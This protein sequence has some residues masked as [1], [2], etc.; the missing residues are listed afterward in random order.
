MGC[1]SSH[2]ELHDRL[3]AAEKR[4]RDIPRGKKNEDL[5]SLE[6]IAREIKDIFMQ[7]AQAGAKDRDSMRR[8]EVISDQILDNLVGRISAEELKEGREV[9]KEWLGNIEKVAK[10]LDAVRATKASSAVTEQIESTLKSMS[11]LVEQAAQADLLKIKKGG[12]VLK[13]DPSKLIPVSKEIIEAAKSAN[14]AAPDSKKVTEQLLTVIMQ[15]S[16]VILNQWKLWGTTYK[17]CEEMLKIATE[18]DELATRLVGIVDAT[19]DPPLLPEVKKMQEKCAE[20]ICTKSIQGAEAQLKASNGGAAFQALQQI[21]PW[22]PVLKEKDGSDLQ[23][24]GIFSKIA[25]F[26]SDQYGKALGDEAEKESI[27]GFVTEVENLR[28]KFEGLA[29]PEGESSLGE[30]LSAIEMKGAVEK[31]LGTLATLIPNFG[32]KDKT[33]ISRGLQ[34]LQAVAS[35]WSNVSSDAALTEKLETNCEKIEQWVDAQVLRTQ[36]DKIA[37]F[38]KLATEYDDRRSR[39]TPPEPKQGALLP[40]IKLRAVAGYLKAIEDGLEAAKPAHEK[41]EQ[42]ICDYLKNAADIVPE[43]ETKLRGR[44]A[45]AFKKTDACLTDK[46]KNGLG[47]PDTNEK[48]EVIL[49]NFAK[50]VDEIR[51]GAALMELLFSDEGSSLVKRLEALKTNHMG[52]LVDQVEGKVAAQ[53]FEQLLDSLQNLESVAS[54][55]PLEDALQ[56]RLQATLSSLK[57][58]FVEACSKAAARGDMKTV[59]DFEFQAPRIDETIVSLGFASQGL[60]AGVLDIVAGAHLDAAKRTLIAGDG[61]VIDCAA[62]TTALESLESCCHKE[63]C[64]DEVKSNV[65]KLATPLETALVASIMSETDGANV[66]A[67]VKAA[68]VADQALSATEDGDPLGLISQRV[69]VAKVVG[70]KLA[71]AKKELDKPERSDPRVAVKVLEQLQGDWEPVKDVQAC[72]QKL[73]AVLN[74]LHA[75]LDAACKKALEADGE[76]KEKKLEGLVQLAQQADKAQDSL[77]SLSKGL[78]SKSFAAGISIALANEHLSAIEAELSKTSGMQPPELLK[79]TKGL[80]KIWKDVAEADDINTRWTQTH[81]KIKTRMAE[82]MDDAIKSSAEGKKKALLHFAKEFDS[83]CSDFSDGSLAEELKGK[84]ES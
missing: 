28:A 78:E 15:V 7:L 39:C 43:G 79:H 52:E 21:L 24:A 65:K 58:P 16:G 75:K 51:D 3:D 74:Q 23:I 45:E 2:N 19:W 13:K 14:N 61:G 47:T 42:S 71:E 44:L 77:A 4:M 37:G 27:K 56:S 72:R 9:C 8:V 53:D 54:K 70:E 5:T 11:A 48:K 80:A 49:I 62:L 6:S 50:I 64:S 25:T 32:P 20:E 81:E 17:N 55:T 60:E 35:K 68:A 10:L 38:L 63:G 41:F 34:A 33:A 57:D 83:A 22:W 66:G 67:I 82:S 59:G 30:T 69:K 76:T 26:T 18:V 40:R 73:V 1:A 31:A 84:M 36:P 12:E 29:P 46:F